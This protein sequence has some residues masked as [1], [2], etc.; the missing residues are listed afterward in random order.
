MDI[1]LCWRVVCR[2]GS[3]YSSCHSQQL[4]IENSS[5]A[6][7]GLCAHFP[8]S[9]LRFLFGLNLCSSCTCCHTFICGSVLFCLEMLVFWSYPRPLALTVFLPPL[10]YSSLSLEGRGLMKTSLGLSISETF[11]LLAIQ[12][13]I[14][15]LSTAGCSF[16]E[17]FQRR[18]DLV[19]PVVIAVGSL[20]ESGLQVSALLFGFPYWK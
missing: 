2:G 19:Q 5:L 8:V 13:W 12:L 3:W 11:T 10:L 15:L 17:G 20:L 9:E 14:S 1:V 6:G 18:T 16:S 7:L 4:A